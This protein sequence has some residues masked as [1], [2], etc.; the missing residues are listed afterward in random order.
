MRSAINAIRKARNGD[1]DPILIPEFR[2][3]AGGH[4]AAEHPRELAQRYLNDGFSGGE[5]K[6]VEIL[7]MAMLKPR[8]AVLDETDSG[9]DIDA[10]RIVAGGVREARR[11]RDGCAR[12]HALPADPQLHRARLRP[13]V[14]RRKIVAEAAPSLRIHWRRKVRGIHARAGGGLDGSNGERDPG[15]RRD[16]Q[17]LQVR[18]S[19][20]RRSED[21]FFKSGRGLSRELVAAIS[22]HKNEPQWMRDYR[23][24]SLEYFLARPLPD[25]G[26]DVS[27]IDFDN[28][29]YYIRP[30]EKQAKSWEDLPPDIKN[31]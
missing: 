27:E 14:R 10:L 19:Q 8:I 29:F 30:T 4:G 25:W 21:Y 11:P 31:T 16:R 13:C 6:R 5:K 1:D 9:L 23:L 28:I 22:E 2:G 7:Q 20:S 18:L 26:G 12:D 17:R 24:K 3:D 15:R